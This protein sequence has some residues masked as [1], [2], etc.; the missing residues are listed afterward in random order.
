MGVYCFCFDLFSHWLHWKLRKE[1]QPRCISLGF[2]TA[3]KTMQA[4]H[5]WGLGRCWESRQGSWGLRLQGSGGGINWE[6]DPSPISLACKHWMETTLGSCSLRFKVIRESSTVWASASGSVYYE[7]IKSWRGASQVFSSTR[8][9]VQV[10]EARLK[11][12][13]ILWA[14]RL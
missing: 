1:S 9:L 6:V 13:S 11:G 10:F 3:E 5:L 12:P 14:L 4:E 8:G 2:C 7:T